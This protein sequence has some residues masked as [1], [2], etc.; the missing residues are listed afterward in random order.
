MYNSILTEFR[1]RY[2]QDL[3]I[4]CFGEESELYAQDFK[5][6]ESLYLKYEDLILKNLDIIQN[7]HIVD[8]GSGTGIWGILMLMHGAASVTCVEPR[9]QFSNGL[10]RVIQKHKLNMNSICDFHTYA[11]QNEYDTAMLAGVCDLIPD[12]IQYLDNLGKSCQYIFIKNGVH[13]VEPDSAKLEIHHNMH[14]RAGF[15]FKQPVND[16][17]GMQTNIVDAIDKPNVGQYTQYR[18]G[19]N[20]ISNIAQYLQYDIVR[21]YINEE[22]RKQF[23]VLKT[24]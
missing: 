2:A 6:T 4:E 1:D 18:F 3:I 16:L 7:K 12:I 11:L 13:N 5:I 19:T 20:Y 22:Q 10:E 9:Q 21:K 23:L 8:V 15:N 24:R 14:H 17:L